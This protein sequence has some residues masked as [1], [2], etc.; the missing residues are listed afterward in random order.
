MILATECD[1]AN[2]V[3]CAPANVIDLFSFDTWFTVGGLEFTRTTFLMLFA[4]LVVVA[5]LWFGLKDRRL[6]PSKFG[7]S[8]E[9][10]LGFVRDDVARDIIGPDSRKYLPYLTSIF[11][12]IL[13]GNLFEVT[14]LINFPITSR[15]ALP[16]FLSLVTYFIFMIVGFGKNRFR[17]LIDTVWPKSVPTGLRPLVGMIEL[18]SVFFLRPLT[19]AVRLF[20]NMVAGHLMLT[21]LLGS[22]VIFLAAIPDVGARGLIGLPWLAFGLFIYGFEIVVSLLQAYIFTLLSAVYI[23]SSIH[24]EH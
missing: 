15:M 23:E 8:I 24:L 17:Y 9:G 6:V 16:A 13:V 2:E 22:G 3:I 10:L 7:A 14:P 21:L 12:L 1:V 11:F 19:L 5:L 4:A 20:A 18:V